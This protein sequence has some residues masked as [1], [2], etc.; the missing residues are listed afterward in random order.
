M[1]INHNVILTVKTNNKNKLILKIYEVG[2][3]IKN[4]KFFDCYIEFE[5]SINNYFKLKKY[6]K[7]YKFRIKNDSGIYYLFSK[8]K[9]NKI[10]MLNIILFLILIFIMSN[11]IISVKV[12]HSKKY[13][14][15]IISKS[16]EEN[17][18]KRLSWKKDYKELSEIKEKILKEYPK[19]IEWLEIEK[20]GMTYV[21]KVEEKIITDTKKE[22][23]KCNVVATKDGIITNIKSTN[24]VELVT[25]GD[26]VKKGDVL[27]SGEIIFN[28]EIKNMVCASGIVMAEVWYESNVKIPLNYQTEVKT[29]K[30]RY[31]ISYGDTKIFK[32]RLKKYRTKKKKLFR[33]FGNDINLLKEEEIRIKNKKY[34]EKEA[35]NRALDLTKEKINL[36]LDEKEEIITQKVLKKDVKNSTMYVEIFSSVKENISEITEIQK[37]E[38]EVE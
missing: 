1:K 36:K 28:E 5:T 32:S 38:K 7:T 15:D 9:S 37:E 26:Y 19:N 22:D 12:I 13:I 3:N 14:R 23:R 20:I 21:I 33:L 34:S 27:I 30:K 35:I 11:T 17:G 29:N 2:I 10:I 8:I 25:V 24:G 16:L 31:N 4:I 6:L 18:I